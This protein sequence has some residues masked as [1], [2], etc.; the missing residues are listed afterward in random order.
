M[1]ILIKDIIKLGQNLL[2]G[3][4]GLHREG[5]GPIPPASMKYFLISDE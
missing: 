5:G 2:K 1:W 3:Y 4:I